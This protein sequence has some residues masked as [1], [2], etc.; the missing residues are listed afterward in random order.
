MEHALDNPYTFTDKFYEAM[1]FAV[2]LH[3]NQAR[4]GTQI[5]YISHLMIVAGMVIEDGGDED[6]VIAALLHDAIE[7]QGGARTREEIQK[8]FGD[9]IAG[10]VDECSD[11]DVEPKPPW[12]ERKD[13]YLKHVGNASPETLRIS[14]ADKLHNVR[15]IVADLS[16]GGPDVWKRFNAP[17]EDLL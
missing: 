3:K 15:S 13:A 9:K 8:R 17:P 11:S 14:L 4:K 7:D 5:P 2:E 6:E 10:I 12:K 1:K 16:I